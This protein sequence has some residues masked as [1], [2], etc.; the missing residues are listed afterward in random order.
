[1]QST[2]Q[3]TQISAHAARP[4]S[5]LSSLS[6]GHV[7]AGRFEIRQALGQGAQGCVYAAYDQLLN[8]P[9]ALKIIAPVQALDSE[10]LQQMRDEVLLS[11]TIQHPNVVRVHEFYQDS[12][13]VF[14]TMQQL[15]G[16][17]LQ[18]YLHEPLSRQQV[19]AWLSQLLDALHACH[20]AG[21]AHADIKPDNLFVQA[22][23]QLVL[24]DFG[25]GRRLD[26]R[27]VSLGHS[28]Y[29]APEIRHSGVLS[30]SSDLYSVGILLDTLVSQVPGNWRTFAWH[31]RMGKLVSRLTQQ[32]PRL[33]PSALDAK[34][35][36]R[37]S[38]RPL[39][40]LAPLAALVLLLI[41]QASLPSPTEAETPS[42]M[43]RL[44]IIYDRQNLALG[45]LADILQFALGT[46]PGLEVI[47]SERSQRL[48]ENLQL[49]PWKNKEAQS[50]LASLLNAD[51][52]LLL[53]ASEIENN[54]RL[55]QIRLLRMPEQR[56][57]FE[58]R[59]ALPKD[60]M[61]ALYEELADRWA[62]DVVGSGLL[63]EQAIVD[64]DHLQPV[65]EILKQQQEPDPSSLINALQR[66]LPAFAGG[67]VMGAELALEQNNLNSARIQLSKLAELTEPHPYW[68]LQA[69][70]LQAELDGDVTA[71]L[72]AADRLLALFPH[73]TELLAKR[74]GLYQWAEQPDKAIA[75]YEQALSADPSDASLWFELGK[76][77]IVNGQIEHAIDNELT[78]ALLGYRRD[79]D[80]LG[81][82]L[83][84]NA[85]GVA[86]LRQSQ[87][88][89]AQQYFSDALAIRTKERDPQGRV[90]SLANLANVVAITGEYQEA[91]S[92]L[93][94]A[95]DIVS[96]LGDPVREAQI[97]DTLGQ[98][99]EEQGK[100]RQ[101]QQ[102][103]KAAL[104]LRV[105]YDSSTRKAQSI[106][107]VA[108]MHFLMGDFSLAEI[109]WQQALEI[110]ARAQDETHLLR[111]RQNLVQLDMA[112]GNMVNAGRMLADLLQP[113]NNEA[114]E[115]TLITQY[116][117][118]QRN[119]DQG[120][121]Q[122][123]FDSSHQAQLMASELKD[124]RSMV[125]MGL[126]QA[127]MCM[128]LARWQCVED[129]L[130]SVGQSGGP[131][132][133]EQ[134]LLFLWLQSIAKE[135][136]SGSMLP[137]NTEALWQRLRLTPLPV[138]SELK[139]LLDGIER[140]GLDASSW[141][142][143]RVAEV[144]NPT[145]YKEY[146]QWLYLQPNTPANQRSLA[147]L[148]AQYPKH[149][150]NHMYYR[151]LDESYK[152]TLPLAQFDAFYEQLSERELVEY[153][154]T[155][156]TP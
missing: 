112:R 113:A 95:I 155:Y 22:N 63:S 49:Q 120:L 21:I 51:A 100:Y 56:L 24:M 99:F 67:W 119:F 94:E 141:Q 125:E 132:S 4:P 62:D 123:A 31:W 82:G 26:G 151:K 43:H 30:A 81:Q 23:G 86:Y 59:R 114:S 110:F 65:F 53:S 143:Q 142:W 101:A 16:R 85:F 17:P 42:E 121:L 76:L 90:T 64:M 131:V 108:Y 136:V 13:Y 66:Q 145:Y 1:M 15:E 36:L 18:E 139:V 140:Q 60:D 129:S 48:I 37:V 19:E 98:V 93:Q 39:Y 152:Q 50:S 72:Q 70:W 84:L 135:Q 32:E 12:P 2:D 73:R 74:A 128:R 148:L 154:Q 57:L 150:R 28:V 116:L 156:N 5:Q 79:R 9:V 25:I 127:E 7:L 8:V 126:W 104:D 80:Y 11:R 33:R 45:A 41:W 69:N 44:A 106:S 118:S 83:V 29:S 103:Y 134:Q 92:L 71:A 47:P 137:T 78:Q 35:R 146:L 153:Q 88:Q 138:L 6:V 89:Q 149:W 91:E 38:L 87:Y 54:L 130:Q 124:S 20:Q 52:L 144:I 115:E 107:N 111:T 97:E 122:G 58:H 117:V 133:A 102:H 68:Q 46:I 40:V 75:D 105:Q 14:F 109:Y 147:Q 55:Y 27:V 61:S 10:Y 96:T 34:A 77:R 3:K